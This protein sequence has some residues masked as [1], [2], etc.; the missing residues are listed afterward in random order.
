MLMS[1]CTTT[2]R[3]ADVEIEEPAPVVELSGKKIAILPVHGDDSIGTNSQLQLKRK[4]NNGIYKKI[5]TLLPDAQIISPD[6]SIKRLNNAGQLN[7]L[8]TMFSSYKS[9][10]IFDSKSVT[11]LS[12]TLGCDYILIPALNNENLDAVVVT[13]Y[14]SALDL[15]LLSRKNDTVWTGFGDFK[16]N[17]IF[18]TGRL[19]ASGISYE[20]VDLAFAYW[21]KPVESKN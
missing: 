16:Q 19:N 13:L 17:G 12:K 9:M 18:G 15:I 4:I 20:L 7:L 10:G 11:K 21:E 1:G 14:S 3:N 5:S 2:I 6:K 8:N